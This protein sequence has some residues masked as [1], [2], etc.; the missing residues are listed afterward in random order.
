MNNEQDEDKGDEN[1][2]NQLFK[3]NLSKNVHLFKTKAAKYEIRKIIIIG[4]P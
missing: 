1:A 4:L 3:I 2:Q